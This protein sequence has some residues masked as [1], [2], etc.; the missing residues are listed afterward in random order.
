MTPVV[1]VTLRTTPLSPAYVWATVSSIPGPEG[2]PE[3][4]KALHVEGLEKALQ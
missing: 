1:Q 4:E 3:S 2:T